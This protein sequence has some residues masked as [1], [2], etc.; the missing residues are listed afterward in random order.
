[1]KNDVESIIMEKKPNNCVG[2]MV[3][4]TDEPKNK[5]S[6]PDRKTLFRDTEN[7][8]EDVRDPSGE[9][10]RRLLFV[11]SFQRVQSQVV[12]EYGDGEL[13]SK[14]AK[15]GLLAPKNAKKPTR[16]IKM[17]D[18]AYNRALFLAINI[19][20]EGQ[21]SHGLIIGLGSGI[22]GD[23]FKVYM[24]QLQLTEVESS[25]KVIDLATN[26]FFY[27][28]K[29]IEAEGST[30]VSTMPENSIDF[31]VVDVDDSQLAD[32]SVP[33]HDFKNQKFVEQAFKTLTQGGVLAV[34][35]IPNAGSSHIALVEEMS[36]YFG[37]VW[38][39]AALREE[40]AIIV[41]A[42]GNEKG[43][44][45]DLGDWSV[46]GA[47]RLKKFKDSVLGG[48]SEDWEENE[49]EEISQGIKLVSETS[50][51]APKK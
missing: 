22:L 23:F 4:L 43:K 31:I 38:Q 39:I 32:S 14:D 16:N 5:T 30:F 33:T 17:L 11:K 48:K 18:F 47:K 41:A 7:I 25:K 10:T 27:N 19:F 26:L 34:N 12:I 9:V 40:Y 29:A 24:P 50:P 42:K 3:Y 15:W 28:R 44:L 20:G 21:R 35:C 49:F 1:M 13:D 6:T 51:P 2:N 36:Q 45:V 8:V 46:W 37:Q